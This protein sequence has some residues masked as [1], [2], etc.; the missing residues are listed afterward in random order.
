MKRMIALLSL[1]SL[2]FVAGC[3]ELTGLTDSVEYVQE[4]TAYLAEI[5]QF[6]EEVPAMLDQAIN[7]QEIR[8]ELEQGLIEMKQ[9]IQNFSELTP[10][11]AILDL[12]D[13]ISMESEKLEQGINQ[14][15]AILEDGNVDLSILEE[16]EFLQTVTEL[17]GLINQLKQLG[18]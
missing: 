4:T 10:P 14:T 6:A 9:E 18:Q 5:N 12:H 11:E 17:N 15:L 7:D 2:L 16:T 8:E 13:Q 3:S 1:L